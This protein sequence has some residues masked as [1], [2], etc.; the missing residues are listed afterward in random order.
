ML[1]DV[2]SAS[3]EQASAAVDAATAA[4]PL[5]AHRRAEIIREAARRISARAAEFADT[6]SAEAGKRTTATR[7]EAA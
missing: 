2:A 6:I 3:P 7:A 4:P 1:A 5:P